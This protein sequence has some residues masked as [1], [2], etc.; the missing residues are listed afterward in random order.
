MSVSKQFPEFLAQSGK[1]PS[2][3]FGNNGPP[4]ASSAASGGQI[5]LVEDLPN[6]ANLATREAV[7]SAIRAY[8]HS[9]RATYPLIFIVTDTTITNGADGSRS[10]GLSMDETV[11][12]KSLIPVDIL[13]SPYCTQIAYVQQLSSLYDLISLLN[14]TF[15]LASTPSHQHFSQKHL[16]AWQNSKLAVDLFMAGDRRTKRKSTE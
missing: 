16:P 7:H 1:G 6:V 12:I 11:T 10:R 5:I 4:N 9:R 15:P 14:N 2:L 8:A 13:Q 3:D